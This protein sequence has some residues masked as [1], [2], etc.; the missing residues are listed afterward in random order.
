MRVVEARIGR[1]LDGLLVFSGTLPLAGELTYADR[2][3]VELA[4][5]LHG[6]R[7]EVEYAVDQSKLLD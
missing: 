5:E 1:T 3:R 7:L 4:D 6:M 2:F